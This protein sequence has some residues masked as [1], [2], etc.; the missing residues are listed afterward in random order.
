MKLW[1][2][3]KKLASK[4]RYSEWSTRNYGKIKDYICK[5]PFIAIM[6][7]GTTDVS[8]KEQF[9]TCFRFVE[10]ISLKMNEVFV[11]MYNPLSADAATL[12][13]CIN[14][15]LVS[16]CLNFENVRGLCFDGA[17][18]MSGRISKVQKWIFEV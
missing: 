15:L 7:D 10:P 14:D 9:S 16:M 1:L 5:S 13:S 8:G 3:K 4:W 18:N 12:F 11:G 17:A 2:K 6:A